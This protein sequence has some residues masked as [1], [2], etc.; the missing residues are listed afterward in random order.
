LAEKVYSCYEAG[1]FGYSLHRWL[2]RVGVENVVVRP[3]NWD[4]LG[5]K[6]KTD[7]IDAL[8]LVQRLDRYVQG[9]RHALAVI[10]V[11]TPEQEQARAL[12]RH[13]EQLVQERQTHEAQGRSFLLYSGGG[14]KGSGGGPRPGKFE[15]VVG[16]LAAPDSGK[17]PGADTFGRPAVGAGGKG[18]GGRGQIPGQGFRGADLSIIATRGVGLEPV[19]EPAPGGQPDR[20][21]PLGPRQRGP[22]PAR[23]DHQTRQSARPAALGG[24]GLAG[25]PVSTQLPAGAKMA[26][27]LDNK[28]ARGGRKKAVVAIGRH[29]AID[30]WRIETGRST[31]AKLDLI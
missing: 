14:S 30:L 17:F 16:T 7:R 22:L 4:E 23:L 12:G 25:H 1:P 3:Q 5:R 18:G 9:N 6:V 26:A 11:P 21:V 13:R 2:L 28:G 19:S 15:D 24:T 8:A 20:D 29:L 31:A 27:Q 10:T